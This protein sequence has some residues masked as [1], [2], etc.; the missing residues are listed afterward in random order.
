MNSTHEGTDHMAPI[1]GGQNL[2]TS[3]V[4]H[5]FQSDIAIDEHMQI[6]SSQVESSLIW[7]NDLPIAGHMTELAYDLCQKEWKNQLKY[8]VCLALIPFMSGHWQIKICSDNAD[9]VDE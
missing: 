9:T 6:I 5:K 2:H 1:Y 4:M 8:K 7:H 3:A